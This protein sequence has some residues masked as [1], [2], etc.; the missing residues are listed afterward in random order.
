MLLPACRHTLDKL[1]DGS[2][3]SALCHTKDVLHLKTCACI[4]QCIEHGPW[5][6]TWSQVVLRREAP[7]SSKARFKSPALQL[8]SPYVFSR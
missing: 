3:A 7:A 8:T 6:E 5:G 1:A 2:E 4:R